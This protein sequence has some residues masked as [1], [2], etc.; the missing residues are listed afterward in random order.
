LAVVLS[1]GA[2]ALAFGNAPADSAATKAQLTKRVKT[3]ERRMNALA[4]LQ[5]QDDGPTITTARNLAAD[6]GSGY[7]YGTAGCPRGRPVGGGV[8]FPNT[9]HI[10]DALLHSYPT[11]SGW[12]VFARSR[13]GNPWVHVVCLDD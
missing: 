6:R 4:R 5:L 11:Y 10:D 3:L 9:V 2:S 12:T 7:Y 8:E 13:G 1:V